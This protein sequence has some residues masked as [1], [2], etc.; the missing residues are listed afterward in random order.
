MKK[1]GVLLAMCIDLYTI[2][3]ILHRN[4]HILCPGMGHQ[5]HST[6]LSLNREAMV[7]SESL[8]PSLLSMPF[9]QCLL[10]PLLNHYY[11]AVLPS[12]PQYNTLY[13]PTYIHQHIHI[14]M[15]K[16]TGSYKFPYFIVAKDTNV[17][18]TIGRNTYTLLSIFY[19]NPNKD[20]SLQVSHHV[21]RN[22][23][24]KWAAKDTMVSG[25]IDECKEYMASIRK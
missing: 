5:S 21:I 22:L 20:S 11:P 4:A 16:S 23:K 25:T 13:I 9:D 7:H 8:V 3:D 24:D 15:P 6:N 18:G 17:L 10:I 19:V 2:Y 1:L 14:H 12:V